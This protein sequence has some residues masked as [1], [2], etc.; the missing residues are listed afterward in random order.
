MHWAE[1]LLLTE[2]RTLRVLGA[3]H[4]HPLCAGAPSCAASSC[5]ARWTRQRTWTA[6]PL[7]GTLERTSCEA[8]A[9]L[10]WAARMRAL[11][12]EVALVLSSARR[13]TRGLFWVR[14][15][16]LLTV[17]HNIPANLALLQREGRVAQVIACRRPRATGSRAGCCRTCAKGGCRT[18]CF[19]T[20]M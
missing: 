10:L 14:Q 13:S 9:E 2:G 20:E 7:A 4:H 19:C 1:L 12:D 17:V 3:G 16:Q 6:H 5:C 15:A 8:A 11:T 18:A